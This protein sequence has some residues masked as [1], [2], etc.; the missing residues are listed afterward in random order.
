M[1]GTQ[2]AFRTGSNC[3]ESPRCPAVITI[4]MGFCP[5]R[6]P[7]AAWWSGRLAS[8]RCR[9]RPARWRYHRAVPS[10]DPPF[11][12]PRDVLVSPADGGIDV[13]VPGDQALH[14]GLGLELGE[15]SLPGP[16]PLPAPEQVVHPAPGPIPPRD[17]PP[18]GP[19]PGSP[20]HADDQLPP[21][22]YRRSARLL[23]PGQ[24]RPVSLNPDHCGPYY[25]RH[26]S[27]L[28]SATARSSCRRPR[29]SPIRIPV[30]HS[31]ANVN[32]SRSGCRRPG[33]PGP[34]R[35]SGSSDACEASSA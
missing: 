6:R 28:P 26:H 12:R 25:A 7:D 34:G 3:G 5:A 29:A 8:A 1:R 9:D 2:I 27:Q 14:V 35:R 16:I 23:A 13:D 21:S 11:P 20:P 32:R 17:I 30:S 10:A 22:P 31:S 18:R 24:Q 15:D 4:D 19:G 33:S